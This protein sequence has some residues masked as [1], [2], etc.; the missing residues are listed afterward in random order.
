MRKASLILVCCLSVLFMASCTQENIEDLLKKKPQVEFMKD[1]A[2]PSD[3]Y[4]ITLGES[5]T[6]SVRIAPNEESNAALQDFIFTIKDP[7]NNDA[8]VFED[9]QTI[10]EDLYAAHT[11]EETFTPEKASNYTV[12]AIVRDEKG[13]ENV[14]A[15]Y[16]DCA[17]PILDELGSFKGVLKLSG[18]LTIENPLTGP[19]E[20]A[21]DPT[22]VEVNLTLGNT[23][24]D[25]SA[26]AQLIIEGTPVTLQC[27]KED[28]VFK[29]DNFRFTKPIDILTLAQLDLDIEITDMVG[30]LQDDMLIITANAHGIGST[31]VA[32][33][34][35]TVKLEGNMEGNLEKINN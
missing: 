12:T 2:Q 4:A 11:F 9:R 17:E 1:A 33:L 14:A 25:G 24:N 23:G 6:F 29:F 34:T 27:H 30:D 21:L 8:V 10:T 13:A 22:N 26:E 3:T 20:M 31:M 5:V 7:A 32:V 16:L 15:V 28:G 18:N 19:T 35:A